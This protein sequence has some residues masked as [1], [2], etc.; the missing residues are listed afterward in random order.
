MSPNGAKDEFSRTHLRGG[1]SSCT[2]YNQGSLSGVA[3]AVE[4]QSKC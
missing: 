2:D 4:M 1:L 3:F